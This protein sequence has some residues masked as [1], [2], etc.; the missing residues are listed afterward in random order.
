[1]PKIQDKIRQRL[2]W[3]L[4]IF[5][6]LMGFAFLVWT[7]QNSQTEFNLLSE[8]WQKRPQTFVWVIM[9]LSV[10]SILN[11][12]GEIKKWQGL[13]GSIS[14]LEAL[15]QSLVGHSLALFTPNKWGEYGGKCLFYTK[16]QSSKI[17][18]LIGLG[19]FSQLMMTVLFGSFGILMIYSSFQIFEIIQLKWSWAITASFL[20]TLAAL[21]FKPIRTKFTSI[22]F[23]F[24]TISTEKIKT[25]FMWSGFRYVVFAHQFLFLM[26]CF[27]N[28]VNYS[29]GITIISLVYLLSSIVPVLAI[30]DALV[31]GTVAI[32]LMS[33]F[34]LPISSVL[35]TVF[36][37]WIGN[38]LFPALFGYVWLWSWQP[39]YLNS[40]T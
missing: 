4:K 40:K 18:A 5:V 2:I 24:K 15:R 32:V 37:M 8:H 28:T 22:W 36:L 3:G 6:M 11:W 19:H 34:N 13:I 33:Y 10:G 21:S 25:A 1:M 31:K 20:L 39:Q 29:L 30:G 23:H 17:I 27:G 38:V 9:V 14:F 12:F 35:I 16:S 7:L 26:W